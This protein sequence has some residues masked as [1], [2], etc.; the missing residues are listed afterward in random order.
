M[1]DNESDNETLMALK[2]E[3]GEQALEELGEEKIVSMYKDMVRI[4][5][6]EDQAGRAYQQKK[7]KGFCHLYTGQEA[8]AVGAINAL[9]DDDNVIAAYREHGHALARGLDPDRVMAELFG[10]AAGVTNGKG[11][12][13]HLFNVD[14]NFYG[15]W[16][17]VGGH[18][19]VAAGMAFA[20]EYKGLDEVTMCFFG[21]GSIHQGVFHE[22]ANMA[23]VYDLP[24]VFVIED[25]R[26]AMGTELSRVSAVTD[27]KK[28][29]KSY[30]MKAFGADGQ[31]MFDVWSTSKEAVDYA[32]S[33]SRP[34][35]IHLDTYRYK[36]HSM[37]D[38]ATYRDKDEVEDEQ[39]RDPI[40]RMSNWLVDQE[41]MADEDLSEIDEA[42]KEMASDAV[43]FADQADF[44]DLDSLTEDVYVDWPWEIR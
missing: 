11:G 33:E 34:A 16:A 32:R 42:A 3:L 40:Q 8:C 44:P 7:V 2:A 17:I 29:G 22:A 14:K 31:D 21:E 6:F 37:T 36:G 20:T 9:R 23:E 27:L 43:D 25:N 30:D 41:I 1:N 4:R 35:L 15:G 10:K 13:M 39:R 26:Y 12:S 19:P 18:L 38:P 5:R 24:V 28:K